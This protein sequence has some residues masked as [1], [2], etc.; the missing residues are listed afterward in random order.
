MP[1]EDL[2]TPLV[3]EKDIW[4][5]NNLLA[6]FS[7]GII[8]IGLFLFTLIYA[9]L[10]LNQM[11]I[12]FI[13]IIVLYAIIL[14][15]LL[16]PKKLKEIKY[17]TRTIYQQVPYEVEKKIYITSPKEERYDY[18]GSIKSKIYHKASCRLSRLIK[19]EYR[20]GNNLKDYFTKKQFTPCKI[21]IQNKYPSLK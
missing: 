12:L 11:L 3:I 15:F 8:M 21:C 18:Y 7:I 19:K 6:A 1:K 9:S 5:F 13:G 17:P 14:F 4:N 16:E 2:Q 10:T 20:V